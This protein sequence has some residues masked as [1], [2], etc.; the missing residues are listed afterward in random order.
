[1]TMRI[2]VK[3][4]HTGRVEP[5]SIGARARD[6]EHAGF[7]S[8]WVSD[9]VVLPEVIESWYPFAADGVATWPSDLPYVESLVALAAAAAV[10]ERVRLGTA[11]LVLSQR[12]PILVAKQV[13][14]L[15]AVSGGRVELGVGAGWLREEFDALDVPFESRGARL[16]E[17][18]TLLRECWTGRPAGRDNPNYTLAPGTIMLPT[19]AASV[20]ILVGGHSRAALRRAGQFGDGWLGQQAVPAIDPAVLAGEIASI[21]AVARDAG[22]DPSAIRVVLRLV[23]SSGRH[24]EVAAAIAELSRVG[25][26]EIIVDVDPF[27]GDPVAAHDVLRAAAGGAL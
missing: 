8:L 25:V 7:D 5:F 6:L 12:N 13:G 3:L 20:P 11:V 9:H 27:D 14:S 19:P 2:G 4:P 22:R 1:V 15:D 23:E 17:W 21:R 18:I 24:D 16:E 26:D 10:T